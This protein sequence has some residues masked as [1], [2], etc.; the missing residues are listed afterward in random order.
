MVD[1]SVVTT[2]KDVSSGIAKGVISMKNP[3]YAQVWKMLY[4]LKPYISNAGGSYDAC[5]T[6][7]AVSPPLSPQPLFVQGK[8]AMIWGGS[9][10]IPQL[11]SAGFR[12]K[13]GLFAEPPVT[14]AT[15][16]YSA[17]VS[18]KGVIG[19]P[20]GSGQWSITSQKADHSMTKKKTDAVMDFM[21]WIFT[22]EHMGAEVKAWGQGG[23]YI[24]T[25]KGAPVPDITG[26]SSLVPATAP[27]TVIDI[28]L[29]DV[30]STN[31][32]NEGIRLVSQ[33]M[34]GG[35]SFPDFSSKWEQLLKSGA[36][37]FDKQNH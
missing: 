32:T 28:A 1:K 37:A 36:Q 12:G 33:L 31:T 24:P 30:L 35:I 11:N 22:P 19:G 26:L 13:Y 14:K 17:G 25:I 20:N 8:V 4:A 7:N 2:G 27:P 9:W 5:S 16:P 23:S 3:A 34:A 10:F 6:P 18:T 15:S 21:A 29:D